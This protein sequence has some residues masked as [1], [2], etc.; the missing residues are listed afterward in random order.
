MAHF[1]A[2]VADLSAGLVKNKREEHGRR[3]GVNRE[4][5]WRWRGEERGGEERKG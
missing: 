2:T 4:S 3:E 1:P 5:R